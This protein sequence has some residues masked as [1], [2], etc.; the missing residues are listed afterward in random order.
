M[1]SDE[2][3]PLLSINDGDDDF[4]HQN[5]S[6]KTPPIK[7]E[8]LSDKFKG[9][10]KK[11]MTKETLPILIYVLLYIISGVINGVLLKKLMIKFVNYSFFLSQ[12]TNYGYLPIFL[13]AMWYK[14][15]C[16][17]DVPKETRKFPQYKFVI[18]GLLDAING[19]FVVIGGVST[20]GPLQ[21][22]LNQAI[23]PFTMIASFIFLRERYSLFQLGGAVVILGGVVVSLIPSLVGGSSG[24][25][26]LF[27]NFF[28]LISVVPGALSNVY[29]DIAFQSIDMDVWY[30]QFWDC[31]YQSLFGSILFPV[32]NWLPPPATIKFTEIIPS[33]R[34]GA[35]CLGG[36]NTI[37]PIFNGTTSTLALGSC[38]INENFVCDDCHN[39][40][41]IVLI[42]MTI[43]IAYN[44]FI[45]LVLKHAGATVY[46]IANTVILPLTNIFFSISFI[47]GAATT[48]FSALSVA[49]LLIILFGL[50]GYRIGS[51]I[52]KPPP[53]SKKDSEQAGEGG[54]GDPSDNKNNLGDSGEIPPSQIQPKTQLHLRNQFFGRLGIDIPESRYR[55][56]NII[57]N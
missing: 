27:Y 10:I 36:K 16:T 38:G 2:R 42:Y 40:W 54:A 15:Y 34:D 30:L 48:P 29:K 50:G 26:I 44:I 21:Q 53:D 32:N 18:M 46:S 12:L 24:G 43:N 45:L 19:F 35:L 23:I 17:S 28:Y 1:G 3:K 20:S 7:K 9:F 11:S 37:L 22:L 33:M 14:M 31:L 39:T 5:V 8:S 25:N 55:A 57:N 49:G 56:A 13:A 52:K 41:I 4:N 47:M 6:T 51:M